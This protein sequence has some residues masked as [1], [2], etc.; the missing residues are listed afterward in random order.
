MRVHLPDEIVDQILFL[1]CT[2][3]PLHTDAHREPSA[4]DANRLR[5][6]SS[7]PHLDVATTLKLLVL[8]P[9]H[10]PYI[11]SI[12]YKGPR[13]SDPIS[14]SLFARTLTNRPALGRLVKH[15]WV[16]HT[17]VG[18]TIP[19]NTLNFGL[20]GSHIAYALN[21][22][23]ATLADVQ[24]CLEKG[25][26]PPNLLSPAFEKRIAQWA[27]QNVQGNARNI[28]PARAP[29]GI[30][31]DSPGSGD[32]DTR[33]WHWIGVDEWVL[34]L[35]DGRDLVKHFREIAQRAFFLELKRLGKQRAGDAK[36]RPPA[37]AVSSSSFGAASKTKPT[38]TGR[39]GASSS[40]LLVTDLVSPFSPR[41]AAERRPGTDGDPMDWA[42][43]SEYPTSNLPATSDDD[44]PIYSEELDLDEIDAERDR[45]F[46]EMGLD[47]PIRSKNWAELVKVGD[48]KVECWVVWLLAKTRARA[49]IVARRVYAAAK[50]RDPELRCW[51]PLRPQPELHTKNHFTHPTFFARSGASHL[52]VGGAPPP[53]RDEF[54]NGGRTG[55][56]DDTSDSE[57]YSDSD[58]ASMSD[59]SDYDSESEAPCQSIR[60][61]ASTTAATTQFTG[62]TNTAASSSFSS[63]SAAAA[64]AHRVT[65][66]F[67]LPEFVEVEQQK[68][69]DQAD[70]WGG[71]YTFASGN[72][73][74]GAG[75]SVLGSRGGMFGYTSALRRGLLDEDDSQLDDG[76]EFASL[77]KEKTRKRNEEDRL[78]CEMT[79]GSVLSS[80]RTVMMLTPRLRNLALDGVLERSICGRRPMCSMGKLKSLSLGPPPPYW[81]SPLLFGHPIKT[82][83]R[84]R[85]SYH[86]EMHGNSAAG[87]AAS[88]P[89][90]LGMD[91]SRSQSIW[92]LPGVLIP[93]P[94]FSTLRTL[95]ISG[96][97]LFPSEARAVGGLGGQL[98]NLRH[99][100][101]S[102]WQ[103]HVEGHPVGCVETLC[104]ILDIPTPEEEAA[105]LA[106][107]ARSS[108]NSSSNTRRLIGGSSAVSATAPGVG[109]GG[110]YRDRDQESRKRRRRHMD[111]RRRSHPYATAS[112]TDSLAAHSSTTVASTS[113]ATPALAQHDASIYALVT[114]KRKLRSVYVTLHPTD[115]A[116]FARKAPVALRN[117][118]RLT[119]ETAKCQNVED[120]L[121][122][123]QRW[124]EW[125]SGMLHFKPTVSNLEAISAAAKRRQEGVVPPSSISA[126]ELNANHSGMQSDLQRAID[127]DLE[128]S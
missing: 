96:C 33:G 100:R 39:S 116:I 40:S 111:P 50:P 84:Q 18:E 115:E 69:E 26:A 11:A 114:R 16:G 1:A 54:W 21:P 68:P 12:L 19:T 56:L 72:E 57:G 99:F 106:A 2:L 17:Y 38:M 64:A 55:D 62:S 103:P 52:L 81:S 123:M 93:S 6:R 128:L 77:Q 53:A 36:P 105:I 59:G 37:G 92:P 85:I 110:I 73:R 43:A 91:D 104:A 89:A 4:F 86:Q 23:L 48:Q 41:N 74:A 58:A 125:E 63:S 65:Q 22:D 90:S 112:Q 94:A 122:E 97:M 66:S 35:W 46:A 118:P 124:W 79:L 51:R 25:I 117:D 119:I 32:P 120:N 109:G 49:R 15:I 20:G 10:F 75:N 42:E 80:L 24:R 102:L 82:S 70:L 98:P 121:G 78:L 87:G 127:T 83:R 45:C 107:A 30:H 29:R 5:A 3:P 7:A 101:W 113:A 88:S 60:N 71:E 27:A 14:L 126:Q 108:S 61:E 34:R 8:S 13:L 31:I 47:Q 44:E 95:H 28:D 67:R 9:Q 76:S